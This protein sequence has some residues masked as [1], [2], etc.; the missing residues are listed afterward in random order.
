[1]LASESDPNDGLDTEVIWEE[2]ILYGTI[3]T[4]I[5]LPIGMSNPP[6]ASEL[7][8][9]LEENREITEPDP[10]TSNSSVIG[11]KLAKQN[12]VLDPPYPV[13]FQTIVTKEIGNVASF[14]LSNISVS[15]YKV[16]FTATN[17]KWKRFTE[18]IITGVE[19]GEPWT[20][21]NP[22]S[23]IYPSFP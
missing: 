22:S 11:S 1:V 18:H 12:F 15:D 3:F 6:S 9:Y 14:D 17:V 5:S 19:S 4:Y 21:Q 13:I 7:A 10:T 23:E 2:E 8:A 16:Y 20:V